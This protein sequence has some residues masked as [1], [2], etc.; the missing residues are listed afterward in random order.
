[1]SAIERTSEVL[2]SATLVALLRSVHAWRSPSSARHP[3]MT[4]LSTSAKA[5]VSRGR[6]AATA[7]R[8]V[9]STKSAGSYRDMTMNPSER[10]IETSV[11]ASNELYDNQGETSWLSFLSSLVRRRRARNVHAKLELG[12]VRRLSFS[13]T[14]MRRRVTSLA[15]HLDRLV[16]AVLAATV[17][18]T[19][20]AGDFVL[21]A[22]EP[23]NRECHGDRLAVCIVTTDGDIQ[24]LRAR[25]TRRGEERTH[26]KR[27][28]GL[29]WRC[30]SRV[31]VRPSTRARAHSLRTHRQE[32]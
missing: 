18:T 32:R 4:A 20:V 26:Q 12:H 15:V 8:S 13:A 3:K 28:R 25:N 16:A 7:R 5:Q 1:M 24:N 10:A 27:S 17:R 30:P 23:A 9:G 6:T 19:G 2:A 22:Q 31:L 11:S 21:A 14:A 29:C